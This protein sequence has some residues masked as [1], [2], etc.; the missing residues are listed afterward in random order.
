MKHSLSR[1]I[2]AGILSTVMVVST[3][4]LL[5]VAALFSLWNIDSF[6]FARTQY[7]KAQRNDI[8]SAYVIYNV[9]PRR[10]LR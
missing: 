10:Q 4:M 2:K 6:I 3:L 9:L 8:E 1:P 5:A 7:E